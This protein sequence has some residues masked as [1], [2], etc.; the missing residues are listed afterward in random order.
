MFCS[1]HTDYAFYFVILA[2]S[3]E[4]ALQRDSSRPEKTVTAQWTHLDDEIRKNFSGVGLWVDSGNQT[5][6]ETVSYVLA[7]KDAAKLQ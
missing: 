4:V 6:E 7:G 3:V 2:P 5:P 1:A